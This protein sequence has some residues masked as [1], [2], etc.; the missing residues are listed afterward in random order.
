[1]PRLLLIRHAEAMPHAAQG[2]LARPLTARGCTDAARMGAYCHA[3]G[4]VP[5]LA[6][7]SPARRACETLD[8][9]LREFPQKPACEIDDGLYDADI[10][11]LRGLLEGLSPSVKTV[12]IVGH[13]PALPEFAHLLVDGREGAG[14]PLRYFPAPCLALIHF[15]CGNWIGTASGGGRLERFMNFSC[16]PADDLLSP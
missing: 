1:M 6:L 16:L 11:A 9:M 10:D 2:D 12:M 4:L 5:E 7:V 13:N 3:S 8:V 15:S 14:A